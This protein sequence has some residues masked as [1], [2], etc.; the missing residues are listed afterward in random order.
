MR[1]EGFSIVHSLVNLWGQ[2]IVHWRRFCDVSIPNDSNQSIHP[3][4]LIYFCSQ[5]NPCLLCPCILYLNLH[6]LWSIIFL[7]MKIM[8]TISRSWCPNF[9]LLILLFNNVG[10]FPLPLTLRLSL[11][12]VTHTFRFLLLSSNVIF[13]QFYAQLGRRSL[14][15]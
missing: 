14:L 7:K 9:E 10:S 1:G 2:N 8:T 15:S 11:T 4:H 6:L 3:R 5:N 12:W 13:L